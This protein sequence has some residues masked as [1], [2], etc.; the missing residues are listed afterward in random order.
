MKELAASYIRLLKAGFFKESYKYFL[1]T[2]AVTAVFG[3]KI[4]ADAQ[5]VLFIFLAMG[6]FS[7]LD[8]KKYALAVS[9]PIKVKTRIKLL[10]VNTY[11]LCCM[12]SVIT[13]LA[14]F[15]RGEVRT[16]ITALMI[17]LLSVIGCSIYHLVFASTEFKEDP[18]EQIGEMIAFSLVLTIAGMIFLGIHWA[19]NRDIISIAMGALPAEIQVVFTVLL[20]VLAFVISRISY[21]RVVKI[22]CSVD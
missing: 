17:I 10:Y 15:I 8:E 5:V 20:T 6:I 1:M 16:A 9:L 12:G 18:Q 4:G 14:A 7:D 11:V 13:Q 2:A 21:K 19:T 22:T 3:S